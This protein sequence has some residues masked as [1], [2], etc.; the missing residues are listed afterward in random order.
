MYEGLGEANPDSLAKS[1]ERFAITQYNMSLKQLTSATTD[2]NIVLL[3][4]LLFICIEM[5]QENKDVAI[6]HCRHGINICNTTPKGL[7]GWAKEALQPIFLRLATFPYFFGVEVADFPEPIGL[8]SDGLAINVTAGEKVMAWDYLVNRV[9][10]L[11]RLGLSYR[12]GPLQHRPVPRYMFEYKQNIY[13][14]LIAWHH[15]YRTVRISYPPDHKEMESHLY[16]EMKSVVGKIWVNCCLSADEMVYDEHIAD[17]EELI[18]LSEQ[19]MNLRSTE[20]SPR[21]KFIFEMGFMP[22]LYFIVIKCRRLDLRLT[23]LRQMPLLSHERENLFNARVLYFVGK[24]TIEVEHG[25]HLDSHP[26]DYPGASDAPMPPDNMRLRSIDIS[27][28]TEMRK[29]EDGVVSEVR[30][31]FFL[32]RPLDIDPGFTEWAEIGPY[33]GTTSK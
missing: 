6:E 24:R 28:E 1:R 30:K 11:V 33:P 21:P 23:A 22:F 31:V 5:L 25:I 15:H 8:V 3:V 9:V 7:L 27:E 14:S 17:F 29:D 16:D 13:E 26:T 4:C 10:R 20:S 18:Y 32:F 12:Q 2:E 19:L